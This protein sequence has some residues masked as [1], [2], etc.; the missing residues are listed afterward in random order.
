MFRRLFQT[1]RQYIDSIAHDPYHPFFRTEA[2][3]MSTD[4]LRHGGPMNMNFTRPLPDG[5]EHPLTPIFDAVIQQVTT[6]KGERH[7]G[8]T[9]PFMDQLWQRTATDHGIGFLTGQAQKKMVEA[10]SKPDQAAVERE[11]L[12]AL[13]YL[14]MAVIHLRR[15]ATWPG[16]PSQ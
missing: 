13:A 6:G 15:R 3:H 5:D 16:K 10:L 7:G 11:L 2:H 4:P 9:I 14:G 1:I 8:M 12:G